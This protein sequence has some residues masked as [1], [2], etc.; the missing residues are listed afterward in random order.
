[1]SNATWF[2]PF[3]EEEKRSGCWPCNIIGRRETLKMPCGW[4]TGIHCCITLPSLCCLLPSRRKWVTHPF[5]SL[6]LYL[7][8]RTTRKRKNEKKACSPTC[9]HVKMSF[10]V[11]IHP[12][13]WVDDTS[14]VSLHFKVAVRLSLEGWWKLA[15]LINHGKGEI[16]WLDILLTHF[17][18]IMM[19][20]WKT[21][22]F[23]FSWRELYSKF[24]YVFDFLGNGKCQE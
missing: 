13:L 7:S 8:H 11:M 18:Q 21:W 24:F 10:Y 17:V 15:V 22:K 12:T 9:C 2:L 5:L 6:L 3:R 4:R 23:F 1:M 19:S 14:R 16:S 20:T